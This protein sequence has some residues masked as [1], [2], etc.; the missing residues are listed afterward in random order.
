MSPIFGRYI[1]DVEYGESWDNLQ[2]RTVPKGKQ[3]KPLLEE[4]EGF[5]FSKLVPKTVNGQKFIRMEHLRELR[6]LLLGKHMIV[7]QHNCTVQ[8]CKLND[9]HTW[10]LR[11]LTHESESEACKSGVNE[12][13]RQIR[14]DSMLVAGENRQS[15]ESKAKQTKKLENKDSLPAEYRRAAKKQRKERTVISATCNDFTDATLKTSKTKADTLPDERGR[16]MKK[17]RQQQPMS[18]ATEGG[19]THVSTK[20]SSVNGRKH[21]PESSLVADG[22]GLVPPKKRDV[23]STQRS[24]ANEDKHARKSSSDLLGPVPRKKRDTTLTGGGATHESTNRWSTDANKHAHKSSTNVDSSGLVPRKKQDTALTEGGATHESIKRSRTNAGKDAAKS[25]PGSAHL[26]PV[27]RKKRDTPGT[28]RSVKREP[29][30]QNSASIPR[31]Q[32]TTFAEAVTV[33]THREEEAS[34]IAEDWNPR[35]S[36]IATMK[37]PVLEKLRATQRNFKEEKDDGEEQDWE[38]GGHAKVEPQRKSKGSLVTTM[39]D[40]LIEK[41]HAGQGNAQDDKKG[42]VEKDWIKVDLLRPIVPT[43]SAPITAGSRERRGV[44]FPGKKRVVWNPNQERMFDKESETTSFYVQ[45]DDNRTRPLENSG[46]NPKVAAAEYRDYIRGVIENGSIVDVLT[47]FEERYAYE[48]DSEKFFEEVRASIVQ[49]DHESGVGRK[50]TFL[51]IIIH[52]L[53]IAGRARALMYWSRLYLLMERLVLKGF[54]PKRHEM[55]RIAVKVTRDKSGKNEEATIGS[56]DFSGDFDAEGRIDLPTACQKPP[57]NFPFNAQ[58]EKLKTVEIELQRKGETGFDKTIGQ[59]EV[60]VWDLYESSV[61]FG[62]EGSRHKSSLTNNNP[63]EKILLGACQVS[64]HVQCER[65]ESY[66][67][68]E[69]GDLCC[70]LNDVI[71]WVCRFRKNELTVQERKQCRFSVDLP[72]NRATLLESAIL[73]A[74]PKLVQRLLSEGAIPSSQTLALAEH[75]ALTDDPFSGRRTEIAALIRSHNARPNHN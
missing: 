57:A 27:P 55:F 38:E 32:S 72:V 15:K 28:S 65:D 30:P 7:P 31:Q 26:G 62:R 68:K 73:L 24:S 48:I 11:V 75:E 18:V 71:E 16:P 29:S 3:T 51:K 20:R 61:R 23:E 4:S 43:E 53:Q 50:N 25:S 1:L 42:G 58:L 74:E 59:S 40:I 22:F 10:M 39:K 60:L 13:M 9:P 14:D 49:R 41:P 69:R 54:K 64:F 2:E 6:T 17:Q 56:F 44:R 52:A 19:S 47:S 36:L 21:A 12:W 46:N 45:P 66:L 8:L 63:V 5:C 35:I 33:Q 70:Q 67:V 37:E 34:N